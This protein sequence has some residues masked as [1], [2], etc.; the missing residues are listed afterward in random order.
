MDFLIIRVIIIQLIFVSEIFII[1]NYILIICS[2]FYNFFL[3][4]EHVPPVNVQIHMKVVLKNTVL[5][6]TE[7]AYSDS[8]VTIQ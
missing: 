6:N 7:Y 1:D 4:S 2:G 8:S 3:S 5:R